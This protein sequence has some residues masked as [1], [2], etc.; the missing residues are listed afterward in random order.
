MSSDKKTDLE[1]PL[2]EAEKPVVEDKPDEPMLG[3]ILMN[4][5]VV[6][7]VLTNLFYKQC[8]NEGMSAIEVGL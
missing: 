3:F 4:C 8:M 2:I 6:G 7:V 5:F 1:Q